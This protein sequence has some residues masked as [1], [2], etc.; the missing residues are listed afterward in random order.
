M[1][2]LIEKAKLLATLAHYGQ[3]DKAGKDYIEHPL[4][5]M[6]SVME[7]D[8]EELA[9]IAVLHDTIEDTFVTADML[10]D[11]GFSD[12]VANGVIMLSRF[13][14]TSY[15]D[16]IREV[17]LSRDAT[18]VKLADLEDNMDMSRIENPTEKD[19]K[20][21]AKYQKAHNFLMGALIK[22][23]NKLKNQL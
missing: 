19:F 22:H 4:R 14:G 5:V 6:R 18:I 13:E 3:V 8:D 10:R 20:R 12:R 2:S 23:N 16:F 9:A 17:A 15:E 11:I 7:H 21:L 1:S